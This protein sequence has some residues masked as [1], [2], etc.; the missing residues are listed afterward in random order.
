[1][2]DRV[3]KADKKRLV[4]FSAK[5]PF[6]G[7]IVLSIIVAAHCIVLAYIYFTCFKLPFQTAK[8]KGFNRS[9]VL[10]AAL[11]RIKRKALGRKS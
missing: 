3:Q 9:L 2:K 4:F 5:E 1:V 6:E 8:C 10:S 7:D 11:K